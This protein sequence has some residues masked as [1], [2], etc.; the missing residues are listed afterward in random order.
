MYQ[1]QVKNPTSND[2]LSLKSDL[3]KTLVSQNKFSSTEMD[4]H[5]Y[6]KDPHSILS[7]SDKVVSVRVV[8]F[9]WFK[10]AA[11]EVPRCCLTLF[12]I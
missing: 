1:I 8:K 11:I 2:M 4:T 3:P 6:I 10:P 5:R 7:Y 9:A 12:I